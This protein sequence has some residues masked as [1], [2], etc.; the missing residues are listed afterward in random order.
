[1][2]TVPGNE[3]LGLLQG[4]DTNRLRAALAQEDEVGDGTVCFKIGL[5]K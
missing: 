3:V 5:L 4:G 1:L 2:A